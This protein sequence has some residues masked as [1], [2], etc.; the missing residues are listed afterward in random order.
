[1]HAGAGAAD[2]VGVRQGEV[3]GLARGVLGHGDQAGHAAALGVGAPHEVAGALRRHHDHVDAL[4]R[5]DA[6][7]AHVEAVGEGDGV[8]RRSGSARCRRRTSRFCSVSGS[9]IMM[10]SASAAASATDRTRRPCGL[11]LGLRRRALAQADA[12]VD[13]GV[14]QVQRVGMALGAVA[15]DGDLAALDERP[16]GVLLVVHG[17]G[18]SACLSLQR[19]GCARCLVRAWAVRPGPCAAA[20]R[21]HRGAGAPRSRPACRVRPPATP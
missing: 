15:D 14:L 5:R 13:A 1:M 10:T 18:H 2:G 8:A 9:R 12:D 16:V 20:P 7:E 3:A 6:A 19:R 11:G 4:R 17:G 21:C